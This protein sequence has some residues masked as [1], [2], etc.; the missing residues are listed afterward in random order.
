MLCT[1]ITVADNMENYDFKRETASLVFKERELVCKNGH[2]NKDS[3]KFCGTCGILLEEIEFPVEEPIQPGDKKPWIWVLSA[4][5]V[6]IALVVLFLVGSPA[7]KVVKAIDAIGTVTMSSLESIEAAEA[8][9]NELEAN[10]QEK[11]TNKEVLDRARQEYNR[12]K[13]L[14]TEAIRSVNGIGIVTINSEQ[15]IADAQSKLEEATEFD[16]DGKLDQSKEKLQQAKSR[17]AEIQKNQKDALEKLVEAQK[18][19]E[20]G[21]F[22]AAYTISD[23][24]LE[25]V[26]EK[27]LKQAFSNIIV[28]AI[29]ERARDLFE[30]GNAYDAVKCLGEY[31]DY[32]KNCDSDIC[33][34][35][36][37]LNAYFT[38]ELKKNTPQNGEIL[39]RT[40]KPGRNTF[41][42]TAGKYDTCFK[43]E[44]EDDPEDYVLV[45]IRAGKKVTINALN[46]NYISKYTAGPNWYG[47]EMMFGPEATFYR[48]PEVLD[49]V[50]Y[51][52]SDAIHWQ[53]WTITLSDTSEWGYQNMDPESF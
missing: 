7:R 27:T 2:L 35:A 10:V 16:T 53:T 40:S 12:Q 33:N 22:N 13:K 21:D 8:M 17:F 28:K 25:I 36:A 1:A 30:N 6:V 37:E 11:I 24:C 51:T 32:R 5:A 42:V 31:S 48:D 52:D 19:L 39:E 41:T 46:G 3:A 20:A 43:L 29:I 15:R 23:T 47:K 44:R 34:E 18:L 45:Y 38:A 26:E 49:V 14:I 50:G 9:Y 4:A